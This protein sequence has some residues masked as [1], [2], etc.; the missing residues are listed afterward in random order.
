M[1]MLNKRS[2][3]KSITYYDKQRSIP[4]SSLSTND[5]LDSECIIV[6]SF[7]QSYD[8]RKKDKDGKNV[9]DLL[10]GVQTPRKNTKIRKS[11]KRR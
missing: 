11:I 1:K 9:D 3:K 4:D 5:R 2:K 8:V 7:H 10:D 6:T